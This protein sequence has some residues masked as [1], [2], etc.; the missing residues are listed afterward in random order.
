MSHSSS[1]FTS[2]SYTSFSSSSSS[3]N[4]GRMSG[5]AY[6][7]QSSSDPRGT[8]VRT[9]SHTLGEPSVEETR[10]YDNQGRELLSAHSAPGADQRRI[11]DIEVEDVTDQLDET[12]ADKKYREAMEDEYAKREGGA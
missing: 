3:S 5:Q 10:H 11:Q 1:S 2:S 4:N 7:S 12:E 6:M 8:T 9:V